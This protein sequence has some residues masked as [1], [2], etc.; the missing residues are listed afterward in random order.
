[1]QT[2]P[3][4]GALLDANLHGKSSAPVAQA[5]ATAGVPFV[6][7]TGYGGLALDDPILDQAA[8]INKPFNGAELEAV[9]LAVFRRA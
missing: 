1:M 7:A 4:D 3:I 2:Q 8:R 9:M 5:L 6:L